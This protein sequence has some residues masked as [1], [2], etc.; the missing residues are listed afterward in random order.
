MIISQL[1]LCTVFSGVIP[2]ISYSPKL[3]N[4]TGVFICLWPRRHFINIS[5][6]PQSRQPDKKAP[7]LHA[8]GM[9]P[10]FYNGRSGQASFPS[11]VSHFRHYR[12]CGVPARRVRELQR[13]D[14]GTQRWGFTC[15][16]FYLILESIINAIRHKNNATLKIYLQLRQVR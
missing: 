7:R 10:R 14:A 15:V 6:A 13:Q 1:T 12:E 4:L 5:H 2:P 3:W 9:S 8:A 16:Y 11:V